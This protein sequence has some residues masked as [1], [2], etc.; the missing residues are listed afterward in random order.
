MVDILTENEVRKAMRVDE[1][2]DDDE[3]VSYQKLSTAFVYNKTGY[4]SDDADVINDLAKQ[5]A[6]LYVKTQFYTSD[7]Y[8]K[9]YDYSLGINGL[10]QDL[11]GVVRAGA[12]DE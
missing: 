5:L 7:N 11:Q 8:N 3:I 6:R 10:V 1:D 4:F 2:Y 12:E 9:D